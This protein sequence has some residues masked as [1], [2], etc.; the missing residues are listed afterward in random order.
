MGAVCC[1][2]GSKHA[3]EYE[4][5]ELYP[6]SYETESAVIIREQQ[7]LYDRE[8]Q[9]MLTSPTQ[10]IGNTSYTVVGPAVSFNFEER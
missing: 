6:L 1:C 8:Q 9:A 3:N 10:R 7:D 2:C 5:E 4:G